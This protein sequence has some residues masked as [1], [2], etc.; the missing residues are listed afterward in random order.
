MKNPIISLIIATLSACA[1]VKSNSVQ[2]DDRVFEIRNT[3]SHNFFLWGPTI[4]HAD[5]ANSMLAAAAK[6]ALTLGCE[7]FV[8]TQNLSQSFN[9]PQGNVSEGLSRLENGQVVYTTGRGQI[10]T[11]KRPDPKVNVFVCFNK[12]PDSLLPGLVFNAKYVAES[13]PN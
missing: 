5:V 10:Y 11:V 12:K 2:I 6:K 13:L 8:A 7:Y 1:G 4:T 3:T 9:T